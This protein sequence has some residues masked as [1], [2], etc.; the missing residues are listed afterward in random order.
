MTKQTTVTGTLNWSQLV[1]SA[2]MSPPSV[3]TFAFTLIFIGF[4]AKAGIIPFHTWLPQAHAKAPSVVSAIL[5][6]VLLNCGIYGILRLYAIA[7]GVS[8][9][10]V[11]SVILIIFGVASI[12]LA[13]FSLVPRTNIR[14]SLLFQYREYGPDAG[15]IGVGTSSAIYWTLFYIL[16]H[17]LIKALLFF[18]AGIC[19]AVRQ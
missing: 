8:S 3:F 16:L 18:S 12:A 2:G 14:K 7:D 6:G 5:S 11:I 19:T 13:A 1:Q 4:A 9:H 15:R 17:S 10:H